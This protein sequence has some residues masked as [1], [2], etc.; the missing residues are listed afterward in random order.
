MK[1]GRA[2][3]AR[4]ADLDHGRVGATHGRSH[5]ASL[6]SLALALSAALPV[7][8]ALSTALPVSLAL[9]TALPVSLALSAALPVS[10]TLSG[11]ASGVGVVSG[12]ASPPPLHT[13]SFAY[14]FSAA[15]QGLLKV[16][17]SQPQ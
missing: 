16:T 12:P 15:P 6:A 5:P 7:S 9:S 10:L 1:A 4:R 17:P 11:V 8:L 13:P 3:H 2:R 14:G